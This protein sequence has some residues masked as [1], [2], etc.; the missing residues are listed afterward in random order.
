MKEREG[1]E[2]GKKERPQKSNI[3]L[4]LDPFPLC[5]ESS[6]LISWFCSVSDPTHAFSGGTRNRDLPLARPRKPPTDPANHTRRK[7]DQSAVKW[8][9][10]IIIVYSQS[11]ITVLSSEQ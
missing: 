2:N 10:G 9:L 8:G 1:K 3:F 7:G 4:L 6:C 11:M 5:S